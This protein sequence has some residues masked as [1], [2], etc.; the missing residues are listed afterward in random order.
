MVNQHIILL[1]GPPGS[2]K[3]TAA[4]FLKNHFTARSIDAKVMKFAEPLKNAVHAMYGLDVPHTY[5]EAVKNEF[6]AQM[7]GN[8]PRSEY[9]GLS[10]EYVKPRY[11]NDFWARALAQKIKD[12]GAKVAIVSD[13]GFQPE[14][15]TMGIEF[16]PANVCVIQLEREGKTFEGDSRAYVNHV[17]QSLIFNNG[18][19]TD[20]EHE[21]HA[22]ATATIRQWGLSKEA[23]AA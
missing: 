12:S 22:L 9:I 10:E 16:L 8:V 2:G 17:M 20:L 1:N 14:V 13:C 21:M 7:M 5:F 23:D 4:R 11:G 18:T 3:D 15:T 6:C 19:L